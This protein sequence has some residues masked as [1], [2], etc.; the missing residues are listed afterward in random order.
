MPQPSAEPRIK[1][2]KERPIGLA[3]LPFQQSAPYNI[4]GLLGK[5][6]IDSPYPGQEK[7]GLRVKG[8]PCECGKVYIG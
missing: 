7:L 4:S 3:S 5:F 8:T 1:N 6:D 2:R